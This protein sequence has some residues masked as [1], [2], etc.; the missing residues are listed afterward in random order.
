M[1]PCDFA[2]DL[3]NMQHLV[4][5]VGLTALHNQSGICNQ[6]TDPACFARHQKGQRKQWTL[7][8]SKS[9]PMAQWHQTNT[10]KVFLQWLWQAFI[11]TI[12]SY[13]WPSIKYCVSNRKLHANAKGFASFHSLRR[14]VKLPLIHPNLSHST[15]YFGLFWKWGFRLQT[16]A[17]VSFPQG[18]VRQIQRIREAFHLASR[19]SLPGRALKFQPC[20]SQVQRV[21]V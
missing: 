9:S 10:S 19:P 4:F 20:R 18:Q 16:F 11:F 2:L 3:S 15:H 17:A 1:Y 6:E 8:G 12:Y 21:R 14:F 13:K 5:S 7:S